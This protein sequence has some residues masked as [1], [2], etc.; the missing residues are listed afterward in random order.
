M[1][2][3][4]RLDL[5]GALHR[6]MARGIERGPIFRNDRGRQDFIDRLGKLVEETHAAIALH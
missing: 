6:V 5:Y 4:R 2:R 3:K 1:P